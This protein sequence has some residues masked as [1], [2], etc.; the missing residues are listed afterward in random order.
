[1]IA[2]R[3][4]RVHCSQ[5]ASLAAP[6][7]GQQH[8]GSSAMK[9]SSHQHSR[10]P[11]QHMFAIKTV[12]LILY[13][14]MWMSLIAPHRLLHRASIASASDWHALTTCTSSLQKRA[15]QE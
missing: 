3:R 10:Q 4:Q 8:A 14:D 7:A 1:M 5:S 6:A 9:C 15:L 11:P 13:N 12:T 2:S